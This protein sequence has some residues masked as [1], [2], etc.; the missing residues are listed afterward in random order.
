MKLLFIVFLFLVALLI[1][2]G[3]SNKGWYFVQKHKDSIVIISG[4]LLFF[5][6]SAELILIAYDENHD[7]N[8]SLEIFFLFSCNIYY[9]FYRYFVRQRSAQKNN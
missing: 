3:I 5:I 9:L 4:F 1:Y 2:D 7:L 8:K 6:L